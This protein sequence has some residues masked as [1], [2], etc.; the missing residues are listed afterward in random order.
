LEHDVD[1]FVHGPEGLVYPGGDSYWQKRTNEYSILLDQPLGPGELRAQVYQ[2][3]SNRDRYWLTSNGTKKENLEIEEKNRGVFL[4]YLDFELIKN[5]AFSI[6]GEYRTQG[7]PEN[8]DYYEIMSGYF[9]DV[10][11]VTSPLTLI[12][13]VRYYEFHSD[14]YKAGFPGMKT[15]TEADKKAHE[16]RRKENEWCPKV[17]L[18]YEVDPN[19]TLYATVSREMRMP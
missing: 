14:A 16:Y 4:D 8:K 1:N 13:G 3:E 11:S 15:A 5:H 18:D 12:W 10:W 17:R 7:I 9:Q 19:L 2:H 6:G